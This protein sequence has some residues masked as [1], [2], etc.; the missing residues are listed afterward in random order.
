MHQCSVFLVH[1]L[2]R[3]LIC[4]DNV[5]ASG[6]LRTT[7]F[8]LLLQCPAKCG[9]RALVTREVRCSDETH[10]CDEATRPAST[11]NCTGPPCERQWTAS[12][13]GPV[14]R[15]TVKFWNAHVM[16]DSL[17]IFNTV[18]IKHD[19]I[20]QKE[21]FKVILIWNSK[22]TGSHL[23]SIELVNWIDEWQQLLMRNLAE[24]NLVLF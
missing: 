8:C 13:W 18:L 9:L 17:K 23:F 15:N 5:S 2:I 3:K 21:T 16:S 1:L 24:F 20:K 6:E 7:L 14:R 11:K 4:L 12:E 22:V 19:A 10:A